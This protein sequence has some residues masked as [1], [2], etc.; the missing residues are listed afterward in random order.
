MDTQDAS[1]YQRNLENIAATFH[2]M[3]SLL[4][5]CGTAGLSLRWEQERH[6]IIEYL[7]SE[8]L[9]LRIVPNL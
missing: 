8:V 2:G 1:G 3:R 4:M 7:K 5:R 9:D 6:I